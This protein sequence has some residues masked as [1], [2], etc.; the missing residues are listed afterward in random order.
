MLNRDLRATFN[1]FYVTCFSL[2]VEHKDFD[3]NTESFRKDLASDFT[4]F[5]CKYTGTI[6]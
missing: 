3:K 2:I 5:S 6:A 1:L 4:L